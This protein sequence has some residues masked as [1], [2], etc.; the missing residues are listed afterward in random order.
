MFVYADLAISEAS[1][2]NIDGHLFF[3]CTAIGLPNI[4]FH[5][6]ERAFGRNAT[7]ETIV[8][9]DRRTDDVV[10]SARLEII[11]TATCQQDGGY[12][13]IFDDGDLSSTARSAPMDCPEC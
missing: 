8:T 12:V 13:C 7:G 9:I 2:N 11:D 3:V 5:A 10:I 4:R 1:A 6:W